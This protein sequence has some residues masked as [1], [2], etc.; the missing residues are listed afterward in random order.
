MDNVECVTV[1]VPQNHLFDGATKGS[2]VVIVAF[3]GSER[4]LEGARRL[5]VLG[6]AL[7]AV[8]SIVSAIVGR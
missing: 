8:V 1:Q 7:L 3:E 6:D 5:I 4:Y 2:D